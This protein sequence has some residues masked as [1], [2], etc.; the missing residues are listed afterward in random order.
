LSQNNQEQQQ[1]EGADFAPSTF[2]Q[3]AAGVAWAAANQRGHV[4]NLKHLIEAGKRPAEELEAQRYWLPILQDAA[5]TMAR[6]ARQ[7]AKQAEQE[8]K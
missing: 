4:A 6:V 1:T 3:Q 7:A 2:E 5:R 8:G